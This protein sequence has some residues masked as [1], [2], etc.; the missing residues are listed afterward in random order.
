MLDRTQASRVT[1]VP[2]HQTWESPPPRSLRSPR[3][4]SSSHRERRARR[5]PTLGD[6]P[7]RL[8]STDVTD[9]AP[10]CLPFE[11]SE[12]SNIPSIRTFRTFEHSPSALRR[13]GQYPT[14]DSPVPD[15]KGFLRTDFPRPAKRVSEHS[16]VSLPTTFVSILDQLHG[17]RPQLPSR[18]SP[19]TLIVNSVSHFLLRTGETRQTKAFPN[20]RSTTN[21]GCD[22]SNGKPVERVF[23]QDGNRS[24]HNPIGPWYGMCKPRTTNI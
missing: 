17:D 3:E 5:D 4:T 6:T 11:H 13:R 20:R 16:V 24:T 9:C 19:R 14:G 1:H 22:N 8:G 10:S 15:P 21:D 18:S 2:S 23:R 12:Q 7:G